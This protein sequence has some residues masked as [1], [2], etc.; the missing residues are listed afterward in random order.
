MIRTDL[1]RPHALFRRF[2]RL[3]LLG[4][5]ASFIQGA[6]ASENVPHRPFA[7]WADVLPDGQFVLGAVYE[8]SDADRIWAS[9]QHSGVSEDSIHQGYVALQYGINS[10]WTADFNIGVTSM[11]WRYASGDATQTTMGLM[12]WS[13]GVDRK[14]TRL[15]S[16][17]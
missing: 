13:F 14:S 1:H 4:F 7:Q 15:N 16:S 11:K 17:H 8:Q 10:N 2:S 9:N 12:D 6:N 3:A 5:L